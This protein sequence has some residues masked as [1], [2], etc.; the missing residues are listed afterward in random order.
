MAEKGRTLPITGLPGCFVMVLDTG[1]TTFAVARSL[2]ERRLT[3]MTLSLHAV[4]PLS[5]NPSL[6]LMMPG[7]T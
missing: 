4:G 2:A 1:T 3:V 5:T 7:V 6:T